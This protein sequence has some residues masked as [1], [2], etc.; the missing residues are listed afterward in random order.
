VQLQLALRPVGQTVREA[1]GRRVHGGRLGREQEENKCVADIG[2]CPVWIR[3][4]NGQPP[5][6]GSE[7]GRP[8]E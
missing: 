6:L 7:C 3:W 8:S 5:G 4:G 1:E 2:S